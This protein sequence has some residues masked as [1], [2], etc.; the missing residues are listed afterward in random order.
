MR[1][2]HVENGRLLRLMAVYGAVSGVE[3]RGP[4]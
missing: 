4:L 2:S 1:G 3:I